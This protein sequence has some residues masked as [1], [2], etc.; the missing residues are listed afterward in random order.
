MEMLSI[1]LE[2][3][4]RFNWKPLFHFQEEFI[5]SCLDLQLDKNQQEHQVELGNQATKHSSCLETTSIFL[6]FLW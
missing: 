4:A 3:N 1:A 5:A 6:I 2:A